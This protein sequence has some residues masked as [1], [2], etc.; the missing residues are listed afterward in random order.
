M[1]TTIAGGDAPVMPGVTG[2]LLATGTRKAYADGRGVLMPTR[3]VFCS[4]RL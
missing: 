2:H 1:V 3:S 4:S